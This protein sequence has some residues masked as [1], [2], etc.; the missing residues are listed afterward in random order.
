MR[1]LAQRFLK[2][3]DF[4]K[5][6]ALKILVI[7]SVFL[8]SDTVLNAQDIKLNEIVASNDGSF[9]DED[10]ESKDWVEI[11]NPS[12]E[13]VYLEGYTLSDT[14][15]NPHKWTFP[16][17]V[18][19]AQGYKVIFC[20]DKNRYTEPMH[21]N[22][23]ISSSGEPIILSNADGEVIDYLPPTPVSKGFALAKIC[24]GECYW[25][26]L[27]ES[28]P[29]VDNFS[30]S[31]VAY[32][33]PSGIDPD[34]IELALTHSWGHEIRYTI[35]GSIPDINS[36]LYTQPIV[37]SDVNQAPELSYISTSPYWTA[38]SGEIAQVNVIRA[39]SF[40]NGIPSSPPFSKTYGVGN[41]ALEMFETYPVFSI[42]T[43][44]D[45][46]FDPELGIY[47]PGNDYV[48]SNPQW[49]GNYFNRGP[50]WE[51]EVHIE[52]FENGLSTWSHEIGL[53]IH[54]GKSRN[55]PQ[56][57]LRLY[58][59]SELGAA[60]FNHPFFETKD[61]RRYDKLLLRAHFGCW[62]KTA[63]KDGV[64]AYI[65]RDL[66][67]ESQHVRPCI[68]F[69]NG[70][71]WGLFAIRDR[72]DTHFIEEEFGTERDSVD[73]ILNG[74]G[75]N[76][77]ADSD[78]GI[79]YGDNIH[80]LALL[81]FLENNDM[82]LE[83]NY[84]YVSTQLDISSAIDYYIAEIYFAQRDWP[85]N[86][87]KLWR[88]GGDSKWRFLFFDLDSGWGYQ[89]PVHNTLL[90]AAHP[91]GTTI[92]N[93]PYATFLF[94][95]LLDSPLFAEAFQHRYGCLLNSEL[96]KDTI[97]L[98]LDKFVD[99]YT[100]GMPNQIK[101]WNNNASM[102]AW[103]GRVNSKLYSFNA[104]RRNYAVQHVSTYFGIDFNP[105][106]YDCNDTIN[107]GIEELITNKPV[108][109]IYP[110]PTSDRIWIDADINSNRGEVHIIDAMGRML[111]SGP[112]SFHQK[113]NVSD[114]SSGIYFVI[115]ED[116]VQRLTS[117]FVKSL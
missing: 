61:T 12:S 39:R 70:E 5:I 111:H 1:V 9:L 53:R 82:G 75:N 79:V 89:G 97:D 23:K 27:P 117:Q 22:F 48:A 84:A 51:R 104:A 65:T 2:I 45:S 26:I 8:F 90:Y 71:Y 46:L 16:D 114:L 49:S 107:T 88:G 112:Y 101:R 94:R 55:A 6:I 56:K 31:L 115:I 66:D 11:Y 69:V 24:A 99:M 108:L 37:L 20:S 35:D 41:E 57:S 60:N 109:K 83:E 86:N 40:Q 64:S 52:Y 58:A 116:G 13:P 54:G 113:I 110:N 15:G 17:V 44:S 68:V 106:N 38:P 85:S 80:Y 76:P 91:S 25:E 102:V 87:Y 103:M 100:P 74:S 95:K 81:D 21:T 47:V 93:T 28:S 43:D 30:V 34:D 10:G 72:M 42:Q 77:E 19:P 33:V 73:I 62:N 96:S 67:F 105:D 63:I 50:E 98:A 36:D 14:E 59:R 18:I 78:W 4:I 29:G 3:F 32:S 92:Y 7:L